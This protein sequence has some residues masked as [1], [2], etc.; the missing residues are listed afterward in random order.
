[1]HYIDACQPHGIV[2]FVSIAWSIQ[3]S[4]S[5]KYYQQYQITKKKYSKEVSVKEQQTMNN[6]SQER[7]SSIHLYGN[8]IY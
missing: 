5:K 8:I 6:K 4:S 3:Q 1:M 2:P 7:L